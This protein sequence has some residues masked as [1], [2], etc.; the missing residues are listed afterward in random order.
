MPGVVKRRIA[1]SNDGK[2]LMAKYCSKAVGEPF[3]SQLTLY[4]KLLEANTRTLA[5]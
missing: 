2:A 3:L 4:H 5:G 1:P